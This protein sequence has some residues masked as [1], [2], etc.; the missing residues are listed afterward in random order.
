MTCWSALPFQPCW[1]I[2]ASMNLQK[3][4]LVNT[5]RIWQ[6]VKS[7]TL[8]GTLLVEVRYMGIRC[9]AEFCVSVL[10]ISR[11]RESVEL[12]KYSCLHWRRLHEFSETCLAVALTPR[13]WIRNL[14]CLNQ[15]MRKFSTL[16]GVASL[17]KMTYLI[18]DPRPR[19]QR[20]RCHDIISPNAS[21]E[22]Y[23]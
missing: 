21:S 20:Q 2:L 9:G 15:Q 1:A 17:S 11:R 8:P 4:K 22:S 14:Y 7:A 3:T 18:T 19:Y 13:A 10:C 5:R 23:E 12:H 6:K 16:G